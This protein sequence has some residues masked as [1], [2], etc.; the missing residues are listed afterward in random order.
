MKSKSQSV[1]L[2]ALF[3]VL[4][5]VGAFVKIPLALPITLQLFFVVLS[6]LLLGSKR[7]AVSCAVYMAIGLVGV[8]VFTQGGGISY[9]FQPSFGYIIGFIFASFLTGLITERKKNP[10]LKIMLTASFVGLLTAYSVGMIYYYLI[11]RFVLDIN[12]GIGLLFIRCFALVAPGDIVL[13]IGAV[14]LAR[15]LKRFVA[16]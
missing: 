11:C 6:G 13:S 15:K 8:P 3:S 12:L 7:G 4:I 14:F 2:C 9:V 16:L 1:A 10:S 5:A